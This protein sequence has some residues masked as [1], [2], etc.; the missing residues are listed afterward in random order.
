M[1]TR[2][3]MTLVLLSI[4]ILFLSGISFN[5]WGC[6]AVVLGACIGT[7]LPDIQMK[8]PKQLRPLTAAW[9]LARM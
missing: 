2:Q 3:H 9:V 6:L 5:P 1:I 4:S 7:I 8:K